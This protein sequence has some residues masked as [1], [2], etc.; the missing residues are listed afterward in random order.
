MTKHSFLYSLIMLAAPLVASAQH[1]DES[2]MLNPPASQTQPAR[3]AKNSGKLPTSGMEIPMP[4]E[5]VLASDAARPLPE[6]H[7]EPKEEVLIKGLD[8][9]REGNVLGALRTIYDASSAGNTE[10]TYRLALIF[11]DGIGIPQ[12]LSDAAYLFRN[13]AGKGHVESQY[14]FAICFRDGIGVQPDE[15]VASV[16]F[17]RAAKGGHPMASYIIAQRYR[18]GV[19]IEKNLKEAQKF[20]TKAVEAG[21]EGAQEELD[22]INDMLKT[23]KPKKR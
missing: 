22:A 12:N 14:Q 13:A 10:A 17:W 5:E 18:D 9:L 7:N 15:H 3:P 16:Y 2:Q 6:G 1:P 4:I 8:E 20:M 21:V 23:S 19:G 11:R